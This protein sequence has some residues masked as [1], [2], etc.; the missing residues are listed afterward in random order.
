MEKKKF[1]TTKTGDI[2]LLEDNKFKQVGRIS[3]GTDD[4]N[5]DKFILNI[6]EKTYSGFLNEVLKKEEIKEFKEWK[7]ANKI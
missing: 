3:I 5:R 6:G 2:Q 1:N 4:K 7:K